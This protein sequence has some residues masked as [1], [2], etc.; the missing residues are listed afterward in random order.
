MPK[1]TGISRR[2]AASMLGTVLLVVFSFDQAQAG[3]GTNTV[4][5]DIAD[6][7]LAQL[8]QVK[9]VSASKREELLTEVPAAVRVVTS[10]D[11]ARSGATSI[12]E[13]LRDVPGL[14]VAQI[15][16]G[17][18]AIGARGFQSQYAT[19]LL[20]LMDGRSVY[21]PVYGGVNWTVQDYFLNDIDRIEVVLGPGGSIWGA[22][23]VNGVV[24]VIYKSAKDTQGGLF[25]GSGGSDKLGL[26][27]G[28][29]GWQVGDGTYARVYAKFTDVE[30]TLQPNGNSAGD[31]GETS[32]TGFRVDGG[33]QAGTSWTVEGDAT[34]NEMG[35]HVPLPDLS[36]AP[37]Y[38]VQDNRGIDS[39]DANLLGRWER[40]FNPDSTLRLQAYYDFV[41]RTWAL[42][43]TQTHTADLE[44]HHTWS[45]WSRQQIDSGVGYRFV[46]TQ[47]GTTPFVNFPEN[48]SSHLVN[49][50][51]Q[52]EFSLFED[53]LSLTAGTKLEYT[54]EAGQARLEPQP[55][56]RLTWHPAAK[57]TVWAAWSLAVRTP[58]EVELDSSGDVAL[59]PPPSGFSSTLPTA[60]RLM[61]NAGVEPERLQ[62]Y[63]LGWRWEPNRKIS[64]DTSLFYYEYSDLISYGMDA[65]YMQTSPAMGIIIPSPSQNGVNGRSYG[66]EAAVQ[67][68]PFVGWEL[69]ASY[70]FLKILLHAYQPDPFDFAGD[71]YTSPEQTVSLS[72]AWRVARNVDFDTTLRFVDAVTYYSIPSYV[73]LDAR[74]AW[75]PSPNWE[76]ALVGQNLL[77]D[78]HTEYKPALVGQATAVE[79][80]V[81]AK[82]TWKF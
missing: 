73:E 60:V 28:R 20:V 54:D 19:K 38:F 50:F 68:R 46:D 4:P 10:K 71:D 76:V 45:G 65:P 44:L 32:Q 77:H 16:G 2:T 39:V 70:S 52:D 26:A 56:V 22:N 72:S 59:Y 43:D 31:S 48:F 14:D 69:R 15:N 23:A 18:W 29:Y 51:V 5:A 57:H 27:G 79:R 35:Y 78:Q 55:S 66:G 67:W 75:R 61:G 40:A 7:N 11:I 6:M 80:G 33:R 63:E 47:A 1:S 49:G 53:V 37:T 82:V 3:G 58:S 21:T 42:T 13:A 25:Y 36:A 62:A 8:A 64:L 30:G 9:I 81:Y 12:P 34:R 17:D 24:N 41:Q 74:V